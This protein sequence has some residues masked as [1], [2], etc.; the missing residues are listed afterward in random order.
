M[1]VI[2]NTDGGVRSRTRGRGG[3]HRGR[4]AIA[5]VI[6]DEDGK[7]LLKGNK[8]LEEDTTVNECEY[9]A[10]IYGLYNA[11]TLGATDVVLRVDSQLIAYQLT[12]DWACREPRLR[13]YRDEAR[14]ELQQF[15]SY[16]I[17]WVPREKNQYAD[18][19]TREVLN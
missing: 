18:Q 6:R 11:S 10:V 16:K 15:K 19:L 14:L 7:V 3:V 4:A 17:E 9:S 5:F 13:E 12:G 8:E 2:V 1:K